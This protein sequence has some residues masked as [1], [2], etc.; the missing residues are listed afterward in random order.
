M[1]AGDQGTFEEAGKWLIRSITSFL[2]ANDQRGAQQGVRNI[3]VFHQAATTEDKRKLEA[4][5]LEAGLGP[6]PTGADQ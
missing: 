1:L 6:F 4:I 2:Q 3:L 5:W